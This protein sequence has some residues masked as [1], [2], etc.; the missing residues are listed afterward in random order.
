MRK[1]LIRLKIKP[2]IRP[3][4]HQ[5]KN[6]A[7]SQYNFLSLIPFYDKS[8]LKVQWSHSFIIGLMSYYMNSCRSFRARIRYVGYVADE[9]PSVYSFSL[10]RHT[11]YIPFIFI[12]VGCW[13]RWQLCVWYNF[14]VVLVNWNNVRLVRH[15]ALS[16]YKLSL[17]I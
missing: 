15:E 17:P 12:C 10:V 13:L 7:I 11:L 2:Y 14:V 4:R 5:K 9:G 8:S 3:W 1:S 6:S 16:S